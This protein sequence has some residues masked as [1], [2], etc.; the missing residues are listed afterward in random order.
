MSAS[1]ILASLEADFKSKIGGGLVAIEWPE[2]GK[3]IYVRRRCS[4]FKKQPILKAGLENDF[5]KMNALMVTQFALDKDGNKIF[6]NGHADALI[7]RVDSTVLDRIAGDISTAVNFSSDSPEDNFAGVDEA[8]KNLKSQPNL[9]S[10]SSLHT[11]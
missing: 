10:D 3:T 5:A 8:E 6:A 1:E 11:S 7:K 9:D 2:A 4:A